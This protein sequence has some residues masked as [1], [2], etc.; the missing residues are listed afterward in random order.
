MHQT[1]AVPALTQPTATITA[2]PRRSAAWRPRCPIRRG[3]GGGRSR[4]L[5]ASI[6]TW[7]AGRRPSAAWPCARSGRRRAPAFSALVSSRNF[8]APASPVRSTL[9]ATTWNLSEPSSRCSRS[10][11]GI[12]LRQGAHQVAHRLSS[13]T[14]PRQSA[15]VCSLPAGVQEL[16]LGQGLR[17]LAE[18]EGRHVPLA[19]RVGAGPRRRG[20]RLARLG[21]RAFAQPGERRCQDGPTSRIPRQTR[22]ARQW[23]R[24]TAAVDSARFCRA[25]PRVIGYVSFRPRASG[26]LGRQRS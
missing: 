2:A 4:G 9:T 18:H 13:T 5:R 25:W 11:A 1:A 19:Q 26:N 23:L 12:S 21:G 6:R 15:S 20:G 14:L 3:R 16:D 8:L 10:S 17:R 7:P 24:P 22:P